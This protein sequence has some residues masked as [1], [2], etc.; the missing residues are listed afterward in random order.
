M[1][2]SESTQILSRAGSSTPIGLRQQGMVEAYQISVH[3]EFDVKWASFFYEANVPFN[4][5][6]HPSFIAAEEAT[7]KAKFDYKPPTYNAMR[8][9]HIEPKKNQVKLQLELKTK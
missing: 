2:Q 1:S 4:V 3:K 6:R 8:T 7:S 9:K 5:V